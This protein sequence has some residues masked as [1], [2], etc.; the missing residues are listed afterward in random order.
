ME[1]P[2]IE[3]WGM[4]LRY[5]LFSYSRIRSKGRQQLSGGAKDRKGF[6][7]ASFN[8][9]THKISHQIPYTSTKQVTLKDYSNYGI[10]EIEWPDYNYSII[11][12]NVWYQGL[13]VSYHLQKN[14]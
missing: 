10:M 6:D 9:I 13:E 12:Q 1:Y 3:T 14:N 4:S 8:D 2:S 5:V 11:N 7:P